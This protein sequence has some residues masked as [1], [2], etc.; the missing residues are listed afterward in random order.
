MI[1]LDG[2]NMQNLWRVRHKKDNGMA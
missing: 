2:L 1:S